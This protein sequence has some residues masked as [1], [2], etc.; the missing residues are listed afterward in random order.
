MLTITGG[1]RCNSFIGS[2]GIRG[3]DCYIF[4][5]NRYQDSSNCE[6]WFF[7]ADFEDISANGIELAD[8]SGSS[9]GRF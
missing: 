8:Q 3:E 4:G 1:Q 7:E 9:T 6:T 5:F 2:E